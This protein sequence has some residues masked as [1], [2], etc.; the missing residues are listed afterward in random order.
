MRYDLAIVGS[1]AA[2]FAAAIAARRRGLSVLMIEKAT[3]GGTCV[4]TGCVPSK[5]LL[6]AAEARHDARTADR[7][8]GL[9][10]A[11]ASV[12]FPALV[13]GKAQLVAG[14][15]TTKYADLAA[16]YGW[17]ILA[18]TAAFAGTPERPVLA[19]TNPTGPKRT[20]EATHFLVATGSSPLEPPIRG[21]AGTGYL[22][23][24][25]ALELDR[26]PDSMVVLGGSAVGLELAQLYA[27]LGARVTI[28]EKLDRL[29]PSEEP[30][31]SAAIAAVLTDEG[32][33][34]LTGTTVGEVSRDDT[35][36]RVSATVASRTVRAEQLLVATGRQPV[37][38]SLRLDVVG[39]P[40]DAGGAVLVDDQLRTV[41]PRIW[42]AGDVTGHPQFVYVAAAQGTLVAENAF[43]AAGR[44]L[45]YAHLPRVTFTSPAIASVGMTDAQAI[46]AGHRCSCRVLPMAYVPRAVVER[47]TRGVVKLVADAD[48]GRLLGAH[49][50]ADGAGELITAAGYALRAGLT[51]T[52]LAEA[53]SPYLTMS[54]ALKLT[55]Q[56]FTRNVAELSCCAA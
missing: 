36:Y 14:M 38:A 22:T 4:N 28:I 20:V 23:S 7:F 10:T 3:V 53:W 1:G 37:T 35:G 40:V 9:G 34:V 54:E 33:R 11:P 48:T 49:V 15:R 12:D 46:E 51:I 2:A 19:V 27:R 56:A 29:A 6:A 16:T 45:D 5:A 13:A 30:E 43:D 18:G 17:E 44:T 26:L 31:L 42:A 21:L 41:N 39:V 24:T 47:D 32:I 50:V 25:T 55:A 8:P 52:D